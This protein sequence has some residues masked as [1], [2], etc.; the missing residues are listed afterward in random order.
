[1]TQLID[2]YLKSI[3]DFCLA[4][5]SEAERLK[6]SHHFSEGYDGFGVLGKLVEAKAD[7]L[8][9][10]W[11][12]ELGEDGLLDLGDRLVA[13][14]KYEEGAIAS[15]FALLLKDEWSPAIFERFGRWLEDG[16]L[17]NWAQVDLLA[18]FVLSG[19]LR[20]KVVELEAVKAWCSSPARWKRRGAASALI[21]P[22][23]ART[24]SIADLLAAIEPLIADPE[25]VV[26]QGVGATLKQFW[27][28]FP[29]ETTEWMTERKERMARLVWNNATVKMGK[30]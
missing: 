10:L 30:G 21:L 2:Q 1:M 14:G 23:R 18:G 11:R 12:P 16:G 4:N 26:Q 5:A 24:Y 7:E 3:R 25:K 13:T 27:T 19:M 29:S 17:R 9:A 28:D 20:E 6:S 8:F 22:M 15:R